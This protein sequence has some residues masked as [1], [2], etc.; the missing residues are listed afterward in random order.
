MKLR[1]RGNTLRLRVNR[2]EVA[3]LAD[4]SAL[5]EDVLFPGNACLTYLLDTRSEESPLASFDGHSIRIAVPLTDVRAWAVGDEIGLYFNVPASG[6][7]LR[8]A[9]EKDLECVDGPREEY[10]PDAFAR[11]AARS[12]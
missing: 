6:K 5:R 4:G 1:F 10:D 8:I 11:G 3:T 9:I 2:R 7:V 12:C